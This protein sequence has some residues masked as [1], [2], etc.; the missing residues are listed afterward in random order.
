MQIYKNVPETRFLDMAGGRFV[1]RME[2]H[3]FVI[4][5]LLINIDPL[6]FRNELCKFRSDGCNGN[7]LQHKLYNVKCGNFFQ[8]YVE[9]RKITQVN[10]LK[11]IVKSHKTKRF[12]IKTQ[13]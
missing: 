11:L 9:I 6:E 12:L 3:T 2:P 13:I 1:E 5:N 7:S 4:T 10:T 8:K